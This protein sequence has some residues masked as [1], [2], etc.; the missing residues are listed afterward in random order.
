M[1]RILTEQQIRKIIRGNLL[2][3]NPLLLGLG[4]IGATSII[5]GLSF[6]GGWAQTDSPEG[7]PKLLALFVAAFVKENLEE[8]K[9]SLGINFSEQQI[10]LIMLAAYSIPNRESRTGM[11]SGLKYGKENAPI[12]TSD[13]AEVLGSELSSKLEKSFNIDLGKSKYVNPSIGIAQIKR[14]TAEGLPSDFL[15]SIDYSSPKDI[16]GTI[17]KGENIEAIIGRYGTHVR[18]VLVVFALLC[19]YIKKAIKSGNYSWDVKGHADLPSEFKD[20]RH[21]N[22]KKRFQSTGHSCLDIAIAAYNYGGGDPRMMTPDVIE[23][24]KMVP[25]Q[26]ARAKELKRT[27]NYGLKRKSRGRWGSV[28]SPLDVMV[29]PPKKYKEDTSYKDIFKDNKG[30]KHYIPC[31]GPDC[32]SGNESGVD[33]TLIY[34][35]KVKTSMYSGRVRIIQYYDELD[36]KKLEKSMKEVKLLIKKVDSKL[37]QIEAHPCYPTKKAAI[38]SFRAFCQESNIK[39][40]VQKALKKYFSADAVDPKFQDVT[41]SPEGGGGI[42]LTVAFGAAGKDWVASL[43]PEQKKLFK[44][45]SIKDA[46]PAD[47]K[48]GSHPIKDEHIE[49]RKRQDQTGLMGPVKGKY[50]LP[51]SDKKKIEKYLKTSDSDK[52]KIEKYL[53]SIE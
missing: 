31:R 8:I 17:K 23:R 51:D 25:Q 49:Y 45:K 36:I 44:C 39:L 7:K 18:S 20:K 47:N 35:K 37:K 52:K 33:S 14:K 30:I 4:V 6:L 41:L 13:F 16:G 2:L 19:L 48:Y 12:I 21:P 11:D 15:K 10:K 38:K 3:E 40:K 9:K 24:N 46:K 34:V 27:S 42:Y 26:A 22:A 50:Q 1:K 29:E 43:T 32:V 53:K 5:A 28:R